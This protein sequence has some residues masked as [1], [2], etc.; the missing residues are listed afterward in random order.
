M[1]AEKSSTSIPSDAQSFFSRGIDRL[2]GG[3]WKE[4]LSDFTEAIKLRPEVA[5][6]YRFRSYA[7]ADSGNVLRA[8]ADLDEAIRLAPD[9]VQ[10]YYDRA[11]FLLRQKLFDEA[12]ADC[13]KG[14][15]LDPA[16]ADL[17]ALRGRVYAAQGDSEKAE[18][19]FTEAI[20]KDPEGAA[21]YFI[22]RGDLFLE[23][24]DNER[25]IADFTEAIA[26]SAKCLSA[27]PACECVL[28]AAGYRR[29][30]GRF[31]RRGGDRSQVAL[32]PQRSRPCPRG[33]GRAR[34]SDRGFQCRDTDQP[35]AWS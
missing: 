1:A 29:G 32:G 24:D 13:R 14:L 9:E 34:E 6:G 33:P 23:G 5:I 25:A 18:A 10:S 7:H 12:L 11:Q 8:I 4:A 3:N 31:H 20:T 17:I 19:D 22:W 26:G 35:G 30:A 2:H 15:E 21:N 28:V 16:R 27:Q